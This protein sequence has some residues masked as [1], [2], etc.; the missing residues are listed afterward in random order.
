MII[1]LALSLIPLT[2]DWIIYYT[3]AISFSKRRKKEV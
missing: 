3:N 2:H 1:L